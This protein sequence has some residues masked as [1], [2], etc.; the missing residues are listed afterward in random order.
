MKQMCD[1][2]LL[3]NCVM[4]KHLLVYLL[5]IIHNYIESILK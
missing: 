5:S 3:N 4:S 1:V 2:K